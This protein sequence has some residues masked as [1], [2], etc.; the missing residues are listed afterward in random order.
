M[1]CAAVVLLTGGGARFAAGLVLGLYLPG[2][3]AVLALFGRAADRVLAAV[4]T[5]AL[6]LGAAMLVGLGAAATGRLEPAW[7]AVGLAC[8]CLVFGGVA[9]VRADAH[10][11]EE[12]AADGDG[13]PDPDRPRWRWRYGLAALPVAALTALLV[14]QIGLAVR[15]RTVDSYYTELSVDPGRPVVTV[16]S[17][18]RDVIEYRY[19]ERVDGLLVR[20]SR[21]TLAPGQRADVTVSGDESARVELLLFRGDE[22]TPYR[23][24]SR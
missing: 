3:L 24:V 12:L 6:S 8:L 21:F 11:D 1:A 14:V 17:F 4:L 23:R 18:E 13:E 16:R 9:L 2:R 22:S 15:H 19:E 5:V 10:A 20:A 7:V